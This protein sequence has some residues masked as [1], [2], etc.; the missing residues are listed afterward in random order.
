MYDHKKIERRWQ[1]NWLRNKTY[2][3][4]EDPSKPKYYILDMFPYP[5]GAGLHVG[6]VTGYTATDILARHMRTKGYQVLH[7]MGWDSFGLPAEQYAIRTGT[8]PKVTTEKNIATYRRQL[9]AMGF[10]YDWDREVTTSEEKYYKWTQ[11]IFTKLYEKGLAYEAEIPVNFCPAMGTV[12]ANEEIEDGKSK[13]GG[14]PIER[15]PLR[16]WILRITDYAERLLEDLEELDW[17]EHLKRLQRNWIGKSSGCSI[18]FL[19]ERTGE[20]LSA[21][22]TRPDTLFGVSYIVLAPEHPM[23]EALTEPS[24]KK[25]V[26][27]YCAKARQKSD[28]ER[29]EG[30]EKTG[31][32]TGAYALHPVTEEKIPIWV[33][34]YVL[35]DYGSG[36]VMGVP[37]SDERDF[38]FA[39]KYQQKILP[40]Y[41]PKPSAL[42]E[43]I[44]LEDFTK[45]VMGGSI[46]YAHEG[47]LINSF[48][49]DLSLD[50]LT[51][52]KAKET[53]M[54]WLT[55]QGKGE[56]TTHYKLRDWLFSRQ[57]YWGEPIPIL[58]LENGEKRTLSLDELPLT[59]PSVQDFTPTPDGKSPLEREPSWLQIKDP[60]TGLFATRETNTMPQWAGSCWYYLRFLDPLN[61]KEPWNEEKERYWMPVDLY[62]GGSEHAV[63]HLLYARFWHKVLYDL[64]LVHTKEPFRVYRNQGLLTSRSYRKKGGGYVSP[65]N[66]EQIGDTYVDKTTKE[67]LISQIEKMSKSKLNGVTPDEMIDEYGADTLRLYEMFMGPF[68]KDKVW[69]LEAASGCYR[70]LCRFYDCVFSEKV[71]DT[72]DETALRLAH[73]L[74]HLVRLDIENMQFNTA[75]SHM[76]TFLNHFIPLAAYPK[77]A[78]LLA[79]QSLYPFAPHIASEM[80]THLQGAGDL[81]YAPLIEIDPRYLEEKEVIYVIQVNGKVRANLTMPKGETKESLLQKAQEEANVQKHLVGEIRK[82]IFVPNKL[83]NLVVHSKTSV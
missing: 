69:N 78:I 64:G 63:L 8:H 40:I 36:V 14:F 58:H 61:D 51:T 11:W 9:Q 24:A 70:F 21:F 26:E 74:A 2:H 6:H 38:A 79:V 30:K 77:D 31:V 13:E 72:Q 22:T 75:I 35:G 16:Q 45:G 44:S 62:V 56:R 54:D 65:E 27:T 15:R 28:L 1:A 48:A 41:Q 59:A 37:A 33:A 81:S 10:S 23:L 53:V 42:P 5:S 57:R 39:K 25:G 80:W 18:D 43:G 12:L 66:V 20:V 50:G 34:D 82:V 4:V 55:K 29:K 47:T 3:S 19:E 52:K 68:D 32:F 49:K 67:P 17:P 71:V 60:K 83:L 7:P 46:C 73:K 76:M